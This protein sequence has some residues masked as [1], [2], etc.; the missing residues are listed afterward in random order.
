MEGEEYGQETTVY[1]QIGLN[2]KAIMDY[3][4]YQYREDTG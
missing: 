1:L 3:V 4:E 2:E